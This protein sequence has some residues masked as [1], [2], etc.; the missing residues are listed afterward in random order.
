MNLFLRSATPHLASC[1]CFHR[2]GFLCLLLL[3]VALRWP[4]QTQADSVVTNCTQNA[5]AVALAVGGTVTFTQDCA[6]SLTNTL[7]IGINVTL[8]SAGRNVSLV[9]NNS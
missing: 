2:P 5:L 3:L 7:T 1:T 9:G 6:L 4:L 8:D